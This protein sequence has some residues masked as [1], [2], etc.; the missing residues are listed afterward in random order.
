VATRASVFAVVAFVA[1]LPAP[2][3]AN[4]PASHVLLAQDVYFPATPATSE[5]AARALLTITRRAR[6][7]G[8]PLK[9]AIFATP[10]DLGNA[11]RLFSTPQLYADQLAREI[12]D[13]RLLVVTPVGFAGQKLGDGV[14]RALARL[15]PVT[16][17]DDRLERQAVTAVARLA[18]EAGRPLDVPT[19]DTSPRGR[20]PYRGPFAGHAGADGP[21]RPPATPRRERTGA[22]TS[23]LLYV[24]P[25]ALVLLLLCARPLAGRVGRGRPPR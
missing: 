10:V 3:S 12:G 7:A 22:T 17:G 5:G 19:I 18:S 6:A 4:G 16:P 2:A 23:P 25:P 20:R 14:S 13:P 1:L 24:A 15:P 9:V 11:A 8:W 21:T